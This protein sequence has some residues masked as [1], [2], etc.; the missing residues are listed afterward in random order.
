MSSSSTWFPPWWCCLSQWSS[1]LYVLCFHPRPPGAPM[2]TPTG[3]LSRHSSGLAS[4]QQYCY[5]LNDHA[6]LRH[7]PYRS[8]HGPR[9]PSRHPWP[10][11]SSPR[12]PASPKPGHLNQCHWLQFERLAVQGWGRCFLFG[13]WCFYCLAFQ[14]TTGATLFR[15]AVAFKT[16]IL[17]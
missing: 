11:D 4:F 3:L 14:F 6:H 10:P 1:H 16:K 7:H 13:S 8:R 9:S 15:R 2:A 5:I 12:S 17:N